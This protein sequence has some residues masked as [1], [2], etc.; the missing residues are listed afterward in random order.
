M[1]SVESTRDKSPRPD[2]K[3][4]VTGSAKRPNLTPDADVQGGCGARNQS[5][6]RA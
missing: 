2:L 3:S 1:P 5:V 4:R 6:I